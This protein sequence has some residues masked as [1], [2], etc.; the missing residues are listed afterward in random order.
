MSL[1][2]YFT[3]F[4]TQKVKNEQP[5]SLGMKEMVSEI[6]KAQHEFYFN[7]IIQ[8]IEGSHK[9]GM[10]V[11]VLGQI[12]EWCH[13]YGI[14]DTIIYWSTEMRDALLEEGIASYNDS[15]GSLVIT[16][17]DYRVKTMKYSKQHD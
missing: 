3:F 15:S 5:L 2:T 1:K 16:T 13:Y 7:R 9:M 8:L 14:D 6:D 11:I 10:S 12:K 17:A 4:N